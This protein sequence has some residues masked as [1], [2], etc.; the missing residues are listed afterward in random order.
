MAEFDGRV[1]CSTLP[2]GRIYSYQAGA[3]V[4]SGSAVPAGWRHVAA[5]K[6]SDRLQLYLDGKQIVRSMPLDATQFDL[7]VDQPLQIGF[8]QNDYFLGRM[9][10]VRIY[11][12]SLEMAEL[13]ALS[14]RP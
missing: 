4:M 13:E 7:H 6:Q 12:R 1:F 5:V 9:R 2:S 11:G 8:G 14:V 10:D 3:S